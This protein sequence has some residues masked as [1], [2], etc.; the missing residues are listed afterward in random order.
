MAD[1]A[2]TEHLRQR[3]IVLGKSCSSLLA[4]TSSNTNIVLPSRMTRIPTLLWLKTLLLAPLRRSTS[5]YILVSL[6]FTDILSVEPLLPRLGARRLQARTLLPVPGL[7]FL[8]LAARRWP[9]L[10]RL[11][12]P[13]RPRAR[14]LRS[15]ATD[16]ISL[17][18][19]SYI[20]HSSADAFFNPPNIDSSSDE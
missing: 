20:S 15:K 13:R 1:V 4:D 7:C 8:F 3:R 17:Y 6:H 19:P 18:L 10:R 5:I 12:P 11:L 2:S 16:R 14:R 9:R